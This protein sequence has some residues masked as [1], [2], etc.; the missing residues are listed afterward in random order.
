MEE[1]VNI[2]SQYKGTDCH[3][4]NIA[5]N[6]SIYIFSI[7]MQMVLYI[8]I[9][10]RGNVANA[11]TTV[12]V[13]HDRDYIQIHLYKWKLEPYS[14]SSS[15]LCNAKDK[16]SLND[17]PQSNFTISFDNHARFRSR[18]GHT[19]LQV[20]DNL[21]RNLAQPRKQMVSASEDESWE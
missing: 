15:S 2:D 5:C 18:S 21:Q 17:K 12:M 3:G 11:L 13:I 9:S 10:G 4:I 8:Q 16:E 7:C 1:Q 20:D 6:K 19:M 14:G